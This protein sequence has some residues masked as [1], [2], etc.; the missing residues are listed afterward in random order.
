MKPPVSIGLSQAPQPPSIPQTQ[1]VS[2]TDTHP[3]RSRRH[4]PPLGAQPVVLVWAQREDR[5]WMSPP[6]GLQREE[7]VGSHLR[8]RLSVPAQPLGGSACPRE[9][10]A[11]GLH[12]AAP[13]SLSILVPFSRSKIEDSLVERGGCITGFRGALPGSQHSHRP[14]VSSGET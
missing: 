9:L 10:T 2:H 12:G 1:P 3:P 6:S 11:L 7:R 5:R 14:S 8:G 13:H 4:P